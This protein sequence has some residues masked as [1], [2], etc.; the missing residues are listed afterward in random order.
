[1]N[2]P[3]T[4]NGVESRDSSS[5]RWLTLLRFAIILIIIAVVSR[6]IDWIQLR[7]VVRWDLSALA[8][9]VAL[10]INALSV[11]CVAYRHGALV[12]DPRVP[13]GIAFK[14]V[15]LSTFLNIVVPGR[16]AEAVK[17]TYL[18]EK[19]QVP[20]RDGITA[21]FIERVLDVM[22]LGLMAGAATFLWLTPQDLW[23]PVAIVAV[24]LLVL[25]SRVPDVIFGQLGRIN[26]PRL[27]KL[28]DFVSRGWTQVAEKRSRPDILL[29]TAGAWLLSVLGIGFLLFAAIGDQATI[30]VALTLF[31]ATTAGLAVPI[32]PG[33]F[34]T[35]EAAGIFAAHSLGFDYETAAWIT[36]LMRANQMA[37]PT[38]GGMFVM[39]QEG[40]GVR[41]FIGRLR[42]EGHSNND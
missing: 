33:G 32:V 42:D 10:P 37:F 4:P 3:A 21:V 18:R 9:L 12:R 11:V 14:S 22:M 38:I 2:D 31:V 15:M 16:A 29:A 5:N 41:A 17:A 40:T 34:G 27:K 1:M 23:L 28:V 13:V 36:A 24:A 20:M 26:H 7:K 30:E 25:V 35:F 19:C 39:S 6:Q 8:I